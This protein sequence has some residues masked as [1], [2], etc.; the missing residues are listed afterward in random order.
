[1]SAPTHLVSK[2]GRTTRAVA[3]A[4]VAAVLVRWSTPPAALVVG[5]LFALTI[6][7]P[8]ARW[9]RLAAKWLLQSSVVLLGFGMNL[10]VV[11]R[12]GRDGAL[13]AAASI[14]ATLAL[15]A[16]LGPRLRLDRNTAALISVGTAICGGSAIAAAS[17]VIE[18]SEAQIAVSIGTIFLLNAAALVV[19]PAVG[20]LLHLTQAQFGLW[21]GI[22]IHDISSVVGAG[23]CY[24]PRALATATAVKLSRT[25]WIIPVTLA[26]AARRRKSG[27]SEGGRAPAIRVPWFIGCFVAAS[28]LRSA[29]PSLAPLAPGIAEAAHRGMVLV[30][31]LVGTSLSVPAL[32]SVGWRAI[33]AGLALWAVI[34][35]G[36]LAAIVG[37]HLGQ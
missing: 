34:G 14:G 18:A 15:G 21:A 24:G 37:L 23:L 26:L 28:L 31:F 3:L 16:W 19:F 35:G 4:A 22:A 10:P 29:A 11:L 5:I 6:G 2:S 27:T 17:T 25:L 1:M 8:G 32:R 7:P 12:L 20:H 30:L 36:S 13:F 9:N 33:A